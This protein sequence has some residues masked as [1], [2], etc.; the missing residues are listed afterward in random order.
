MSRYCI[1]VQRHQGK[2]DEWDWFLLDIEKP[3]FSDLPIACVRDTS[4]NYDSKYKTAADA[5]LEGFE[6]LARQLAVK[7]RIDP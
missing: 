6:A 7:V 1:S 3:V 4:Y 5:K 2:S